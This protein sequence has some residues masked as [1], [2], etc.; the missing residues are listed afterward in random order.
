MWDNVLIKFSHGVRFIVTWLIIV[1]DEFLEQ[2]I[3][4]CSN[5]NLYKNLRFIQQ[6]WRN[7]LTH[8]LEY[9]WLKF[10][11]SSQCCLLLYSVSVKGTTQG[12]STHTQHFLHKTTAV[13][14]QLVVHSL[15]IFLT[16][17]QQRT[18]GSAELRDLIRVISFNVTEFECVGACAG[19]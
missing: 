2:V 9:F 16:L 18:T 4:L 8:S 10:S 7:N 12:G 19:H 5:R 13:W 17:V 11:S 6:S 3:H 1:N 14:K 15:A